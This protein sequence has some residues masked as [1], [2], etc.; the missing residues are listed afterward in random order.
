MS[1]PEQ[2]G[3]DVAMLLADAAESVGGKLYVLGG[4]WSVILRSDTPTNMALGVKLGVPWHQ[5]NRPIQLRASLLTEDGEPVEVGGTTVF[6]EAELEVGRPPGVRP[7]TSIDAPF[8]LNFGGLALPA[9]GYVWELRI[10]GEPRARSPFR[11]LG[12]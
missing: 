10:D 4:G 6:T 9:G 7:G 11:V 3:W 5:T 8:V 12:S 1:Q 2:A